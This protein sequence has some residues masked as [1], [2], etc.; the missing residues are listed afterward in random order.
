MAEAIVKAE[1]QPPGF[2]AG[3]KIMVL[4]L[5]EGI[6]REAPPP[7]HLMTTTSDSARGGAIAYGL[8]KA[9][10]S[11]ASQGR[12]HVIMYTD[13]DLQMDLTQAGKL[14]HRVLVGGCCMAGGV[15]YGHPRS[16]LV[17]PPGG[18][19]PHPTSHLEQ[20]NVLQI[21]LRH[22]MRRTLLPEVGS[23]FCDANCGF[24][25]F[26]AD[27]LRAVL[28]QLTRFKKGFDIE[29]LQLVAKRMRGSHQSHQ[30]H[31]QLAAATLA[32]R[33]CLD[34]SF[35]PL[36][37]ARLSGREGVSGPMAVVPVIFVE[38]CRELIP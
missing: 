22:W 7:L 26:H 25:A 11:T 20:H 5:G 2:A 13:A 35:K 6:G 8:V 29:L 19:V 34:E 28:P 33:L 14:A 15:R 27:T 24:K 1:G 3:K 10:E 23:D 17:K 18:A 38:V 32:A 30:Q 12:A 9:L 4:R 37:Q 31:Q 21:T 16:L 36:P